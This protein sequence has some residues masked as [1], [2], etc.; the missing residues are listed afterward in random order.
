MMSVVVGPL[1]EDR[2]ASL[3]SILLTNR[4]RE[5][6]LGTGEEYSLFAL[7]ATCRPDMEPR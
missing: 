3:T 7:P 5:P 4:R 6:K 1:L 2:K